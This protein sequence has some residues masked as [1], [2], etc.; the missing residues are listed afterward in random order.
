M[1]SRN[2]YRRIAH[3]LWGGWEL[4]GFITWVG[5]G[6]LSNAMALVFFPFAQALPIW[7]KILY[8]VG[9]F[10]AALIVSVII[11]R[12]LQA[13]FKQQTDTGLSQSVTG[14]HIGRDNIQAGRDVYVNISSEHTR[15]NNKNH[16][17]LPN[18]P[19]L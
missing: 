5:G 16:P 19:E 3:F 10:G 7:L 8:G 15:L 18:P 14:S 9:L 6:V 11:I 13:L 4:Y 17:K 12:I 2:R 1:G